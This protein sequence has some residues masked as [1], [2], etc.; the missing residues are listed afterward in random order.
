MSYANPRMTDLNKPLMQMMI[1]F[2]DGNPGAVISQVKGVWDD[3][4][5]C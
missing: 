1:D 3:D 5:N 2:V 4:Q